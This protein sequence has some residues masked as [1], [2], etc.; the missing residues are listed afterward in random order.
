M[1]GD[2]FWYPTFPFHLPCQHLHLY[3]VETGTSLQRFVFLNFSS[4]NMK[5]TNDCEPQKQRRNSD[6]H[7]TVPGHMDPHHRETHSL[8]VGAS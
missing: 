7:I 8:I 2:M 1:L 3:Q 6:L 5:R 4:N